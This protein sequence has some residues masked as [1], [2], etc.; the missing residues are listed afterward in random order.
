MTSTPQEQVEQGAERAV[1]PLIGAVQAEPA[2]TIHSSSTGSS[3]STGNS[4]ATE[5]MLRRQEEQEE[6]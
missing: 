4:K 3:T 2:E 6:N 5:S 1:P